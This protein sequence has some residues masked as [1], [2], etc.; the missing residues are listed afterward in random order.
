M[1]ENV[2]AMG[3]VA[4]LSLAVCMFFTYAVPDAP[5]TPASTTVIVGFCAAVVASSR[6]AWKASSR[7]RRPGG[8]T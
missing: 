3:I 8:A 7:L 1:N 6:W 2:R 5:L 4:A